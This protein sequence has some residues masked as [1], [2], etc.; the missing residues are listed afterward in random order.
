LRLSREQSTYDAARLIYRTL[1]V[2]L[3]VNEAGVLAD[4]DS[5]FLHD[6]R[7]AVRRTRSALKELPGA[8]PADV[9]ERF[10]EEFRWLGQVTT[11]TRDLDVY[12]LEFPSFRAVVGDAADDLEHLR[13][14]IVADQRAA[15]AQLGEDLR[16]E[17][18]HRLVDDWAAAVRDSKP[19][20]GPGPVGAVAIGATADLRIAKVAG[21]VLRDGGRIDD[22]TPAEKLHDLRKRCKELRYLLEFFVSLYDPKLHGP[23]L[24]ALKGLQDN[25]GQ[26]QDTHV[27]RLAVEGF[28]DRL[29]ADRDTS[30]PA[31]MAVGRLV[32]AFD[33]RERRARAEFAE[34]FGSFAGQRNRERIERLT[35]GRS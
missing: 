29:A 33:D 34:R 3:T 9:E 1:L 26:F 23:V 22:S 20:T 21:R 10:R 19:S 27:Q 16:S 35:A 32:A 8:L 15:H 17:R 13:R 18:Y 2:T 30:A 28:A 7:V 6:Y 11:P 12:L 25:L 4:L 24:S 31:L 14:L 5:E